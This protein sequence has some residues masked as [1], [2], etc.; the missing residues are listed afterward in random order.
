[1]DL[2]ASMLLIARSN[3]PPEFA[4]NVQVRNEDFMTAPFDLASFDLIICVGV[5]AHVDCP[6]ELLKEDG[7]P[8]E[9]WG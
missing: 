6:D 9:A 8:S 7:Y 1:M 4:A 3:V 2:S 5:L